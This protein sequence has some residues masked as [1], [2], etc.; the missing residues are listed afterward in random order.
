MFYHFFISLITQPNNTFV[1][2][3]AS[4]TTN[5]TVNTPTKPLHECSNCV[6]FFMP[7]TLFK[8]VRA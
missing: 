3:Q 2:T 4:V 8:E 5:I 6:G 7:V 1:L